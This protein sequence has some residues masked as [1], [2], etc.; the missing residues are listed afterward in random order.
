MI[1][2]IITVTIII[3]FS[4]NSIDNKQEILRRG[5]TTVIIITIIIAGLN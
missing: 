1:I 5:T 4:I 3:H 2:T